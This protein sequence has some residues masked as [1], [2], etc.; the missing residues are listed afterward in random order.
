MKQTFFLLAI[1]AV[2]VSCQ[3]Y[4]YFYPVAGINAGDATLCFISGR[5]L[6][7]HAIAMMKT[8]E[9][10]TDFLPLIS[11]YQRVTKACASL[12]KEWTNWD[13]YPRGCYDYVAPVAA[14]FHKLVSL[15]KSKNP[16][17]V[18]SEMVAIKLIVK[19]VIA[20]QQEY[21][22]ACFPSN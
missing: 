8:G 17:P 10:T 3:K 22:N 2:S 14:A 18:L 1:L 5:D 21:Y 11:K 15:F 20:N 13:N 4:P 9:V 16:A 12:N 6:V 19:H 7:Q